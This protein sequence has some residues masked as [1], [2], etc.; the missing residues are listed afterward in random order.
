M[1]L[2][3]WGARQLVPYGNPLLGAAL[4]AYGWVH[5]GIGS[6]IVGHC[7]PPGTQP[8]RVAWSESGPYRVVQVHHRV[9]NLLNRPY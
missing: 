3:D 8:A 9:L 4:A 6:I 2:T 7:R 1:S 5:I